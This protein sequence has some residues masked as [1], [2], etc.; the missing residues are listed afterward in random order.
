MPWE[1]RIKI[2]C[3]GRTG[4][5]RTKGFIFKACMSSD[6]NSLFSFSYCF[7]LKSGQYKCSIL[8]PSFTGPR[9]SL[10]PMASGSIGWTKTYH[11]QQP[12]FKT[13]GEP[14]Q[15]GSP[16]TAPNNTS[17]THGHFH[18]ILKTPFFSCTSHMRTLLSHISTGQYW[19]INSYTD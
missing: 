1:N 18:L 16:A 7:P 5:G 19:S 8:S 11:L 17:T 2:L 6:C 9:M 10:N 4:K 15:S 14:G 13:E 12:M 3:G